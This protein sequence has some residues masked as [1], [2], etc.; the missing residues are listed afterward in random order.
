MTQ[1]PGTRLGRYGTL[2]FVHLTECL[3]NLRIISCVEGQGMGSVTFH[4]NE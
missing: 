4:I 2:S 3:L 1:V